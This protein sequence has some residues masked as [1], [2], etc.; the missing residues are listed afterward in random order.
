MATNASNGR[1]GVLS[2]ADTA[3]EISN[4]PEPAHSGGRRG[5]GRKS[6]F[7]RKLFSS[8]LIIRCLVFLLFSAGAASAIAPSFTVDPINEIDGDMD[9]AYSSTLA[10]DAS[11]PESDPMTFSKISGPAWLSVAS[12]GDLSGTPDASDVGDN[13]FAVQVSA[14]DGSDVATGRRCHLGGSKS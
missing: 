1:D 11:D 9:T 13:A 4:T 5:A 6:F 2:A 10:D 8:G 14:T 3:K 7:M 12:N